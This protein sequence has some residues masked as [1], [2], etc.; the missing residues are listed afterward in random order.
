MFAR[1]L[2]VQATQELFA[3]IASNPPA[4]LTAERQPDVDREAEPN[5][6][7][8]TVSFMWSG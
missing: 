8:H 1:R 6:R 3:Q 2:N 7:T 5:R 4:G